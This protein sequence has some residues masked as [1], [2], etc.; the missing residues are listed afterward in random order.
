MQ[1]PVMPRVADEQPEIIR[2]R[3]VVA[4]LEHAASHDLLTGLPNREVLLDRL[5]RELTR[6]ATE[7][8]RIAILLVDLDNFKLAN[9]SLGHT[10]GEVLRE[11]AKRVVGCL[12]TEDTASANKT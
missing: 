9:D 5:T 11:M 6:T 2:L 10:G 1:Y 4:R 8:E 3:N 12:G 7:G